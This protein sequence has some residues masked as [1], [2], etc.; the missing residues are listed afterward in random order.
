VED[1]FTLHRLKRR[2]IQKARLIALLYEHCTDNKEK[3]DEILV[4]RYLPLAD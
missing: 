4:K 1:Y 3:P 2:S